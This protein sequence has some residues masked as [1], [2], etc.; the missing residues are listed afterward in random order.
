MTQILWARYF[1]VLK[2][3]NFTYQFT[4]TCRRE[5]E[6]IKI[7]H[8]FTRKIID[9]RRTYIEKYGNNFDTSIDQDIYSGSKKKLAF[10][11]LLLQF[12]RDD[13]EK[14]NN[15]GIR[16]EVDTF[17]FEGH[18]TTTSAISFA[19]LNL[20]KYPDAQQLVFEESQNILGDKMAS[21]IQDL[22]QLTY[23]EKFIKETLRLYPSVRKSE[24]F[25]EIFYAIFNKLKFYAKF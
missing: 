14:L 15:E 17:V 2:R 10:L 4:N 1:N 24:I 12:Q 20:A 22:N 5:K 11:D 9:E 7:M 23:L 25:L 6:L 16:E 3:I 21:T 8:K 18:D 19:L 13:P